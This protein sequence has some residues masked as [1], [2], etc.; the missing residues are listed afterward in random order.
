MSMNSSISLV[1]KAVVIFET[2]YGNTERIAK[3]LTK[4][5]RKSGMET[6]CYNMNDLQIGT[7]TECEFIAIGAP[8][9]YRTASEPMKG[10][11]EKVER[12]D[13]RGKYGFAF[14]TRV[15]SFWAGS[16]AEFIE[17]KLKSVGLQ[18]VRPRSSAIVRHADEGGKKSKES[19]GKGGKE[20]KGCAG[21]WHGRA[22]REYRRRDRA[23]PG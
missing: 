7:F 19:P 1:K 20:V 3:A 16:A 6:T 15:D 8:T 9:Q 11:L 22:V 2:R 4:G 14:D 18:I 5:I 10:F 12:V 13:L 21:G 23:N 17:K